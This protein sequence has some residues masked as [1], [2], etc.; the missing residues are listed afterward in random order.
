MLDELKGFEKGLC[1]KCKH[2]DIDAWIQY[3][4]KSEAVRGAIACKSNGV[5]G[6]NNVACTCFERRKNI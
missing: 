1:F 6:E 3:E 2:F 4:G 5:A